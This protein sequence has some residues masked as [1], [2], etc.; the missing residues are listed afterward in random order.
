MNCPLIPI[1]RILYYLVSND[2]LFQWNCWQTKTLEV[3]SK[4]CLVNLFAQQMNS[5]IPEDNTYIYFVAYAH[6][7]STQMLLVKILHKFATSEN[8]AP[9]FLLILR[10]VKDN[11]NDNFLKKY[12]PNFSLEKTENENSTTN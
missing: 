6:L 9:C 8:S 11:H 5:Y 3:T 2:N 4:S 10:K 12:C 7:Q 1:N